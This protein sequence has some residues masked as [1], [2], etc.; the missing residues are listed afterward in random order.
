MCIY[1]LIHY[2]CVNLGFNDYSFDIEK[3]PRRTPKPKKRLVIGCQS[4]PST[5]SIRYTYII[6]N[7]Y[8]HV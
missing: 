6:L 5:Y 8:V 7:N 4:R 1:Q 2:V 3:R